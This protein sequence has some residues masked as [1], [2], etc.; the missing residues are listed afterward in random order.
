MHEVRVLVVDDFEPWRDFVRCAF[1]KQPELQIVGEAVNGLEAVQKVLELGP[2]LIVMD[3]GLPV[4]NGMDATRRVRDCN[5][6]TK[7]LFLSQIQSL[8]VI[9]QAASTG[10]SG[11]VVKADA[12]KELLPSVN[13]ALR[14]AQ[15]VSSRLDDSGFHD[16]YS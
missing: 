10:P 6:Q 4:L 3:V 9:K 15:F 13:A 8:E 14:G 16:G 2:D 12:A 7:I 5:P 11:Y 1:L